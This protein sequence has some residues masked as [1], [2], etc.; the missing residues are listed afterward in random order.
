[1][2]MLAPTKL[3]LGSLVAA[4]DL[5]VYQSFVPSLFHGTFLGKYYDRSVGRMMNTHGVA[6]AECAGIFIVLPKS[7][8]LVREIPST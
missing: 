4:N 6:T 1:M 3:F 7:A 2:W 5:D 8:A